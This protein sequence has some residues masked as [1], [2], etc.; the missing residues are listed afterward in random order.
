M[1]ILDSSGTTSSS[2]TGGTSLTFANNQ[3]VRNSASSCTDTKRLQRGE[4]RRL[5]TPLARRAAQ[6]RPEPSDRM[7]ADPIA[8]ARQLDD[9]STVHAKDTRIEPAIAG[10]NG[11]I[12]ARSPTVS[13]RGWNYVTLG[14]GH[15]EAWWK[16][17]RRELPPPATTTCCRS[18]TRTEFKARG[19][20]SAIGRV[21]FAVTPTEQMLARALGSLIARMAWASPAM[22]SE[23]QPAVPRCA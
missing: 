11:V 14:Y 6:L 8:G 7:G 20:L 3:G 22:T 2:R 9:A 18:S 1:S 16:D 5:P 21:R 19:L 4:L 10:V 15:D 13:E 17:S 12:D 23:A